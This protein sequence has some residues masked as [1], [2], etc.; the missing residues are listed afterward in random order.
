MRYGYIRISADDQPFETQLAALKKA[1]CKTVFKD[2]QN[3]TVA[4]PALEQCLS[5]LKTGDTLTVWKLNR[6]SCNLRNLVRMLDE[7]RERGIKFRSLTEAIDTAA[8]AGSAMWQIIRVLA[9]FERS[10]STER[11][12]VGIALAKERG[13]YTGR[14]VGTTKAEP[15]RARALKKQGLKIPEIAQ[16]LAVKERT[17]YHYLRTAPA[18]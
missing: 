12:A 16:A 9:E 15:A 8:P 14:K 13:V 7:F 2:E 5:K 17:V 10:Q 6:L 1:G 3:A 11:Q 18:K 4:R